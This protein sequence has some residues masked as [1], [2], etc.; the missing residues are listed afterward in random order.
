MSPRAGMLETP[1]GRSRAGQLA[2]IHSPFYP[3]QVTDMQSSAPTF[4]KLPGIT[5][6]EFIFKNIKFQNLGRV[7]KQKRNAL[8]TSTAGLLPGSGSAPGSPSSRS[9]H[10]DGIPP[11]R[12]VAYTS[13][14]EATTAP[15]GAAPA[16]R[17]LA[18]PRPFPRRFPRRTHL[19]K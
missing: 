12:N 3:R 17:A 11:R 10:R 4:Q 13:D 1:R 6:I 19:R 7:A 14:P 8:S 18:G 2:P 9:S 16:R 5:V 15:R